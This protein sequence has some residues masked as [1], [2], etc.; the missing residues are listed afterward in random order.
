MQNIVPIN[1]YE[2][3]YLPRYL[4][5]EIITIIANSLF[6]NSFLCFPLLSSCVDVILVSVFSIG[7]LKSN[8]FAARFQIISSQKL[9]N[10]S[11]ILHRLIKFV[12]GAS[13]PKICCHPAGNLLLATKFHNFCHNHAGTHS[14]DPTLLSLAAIET[15]P[16]YGSSKDSTTVSLKKSV[17]KSHNITP[18]RSSDPIMCPS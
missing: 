5:Y 12:H 11:F 15:N 14:D 8:L 6:H 4:V 7:T 9:S 13:N 10:Y 17:R 18:I 3:Q 1:K 16:V 2:V